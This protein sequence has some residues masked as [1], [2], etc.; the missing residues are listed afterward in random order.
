MKRYLLGALAAGTLILGT[1]FAQKPGAEHFRARQINQASRIN[2]GLRNGSLTP[3]QAAGLRRQDRRIASQA[4]AMN[5][6]DGTTPAQRA[7]IHHEMNQ[8]SRRIYNEKH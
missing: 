3:R 1:A 6:A 4:R 5:R 7:Q 8:E 2:R